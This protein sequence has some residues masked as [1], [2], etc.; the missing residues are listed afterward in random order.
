VALFRPRLSRRQQGKFG[1]EQLGNTPQA[2]TRLALINA[3][4]Y[5]ER[6]RQHFVQQPKSHERFDALLSTLPPGCALDVSS[7]SSIDPAGPG[8]MP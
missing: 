5:L 3:A 1:G 2:L 7:W 4:F 6:Q 8:S